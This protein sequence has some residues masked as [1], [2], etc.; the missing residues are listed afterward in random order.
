MCFAIF[1]FESFLR[2]D[3]H[4]TQKQFGSLV[5]PIFLYVGLY[6]YTLD[7]QVNPAE[8][9]RNPQMKR[10]YLQACGP[11]SW[12]PGLYEAGWSS[13]TKLFWNSNQNRQSYFLSFSVAKVKSKLQLKHSIST[14]YSTF[15]N[16]YPR[17]CVARTRWIIHNLQPAKPQDVLLILIALFRP[18]PGQVKS[19]DVTKNKSSMGNSRPSLSLWRH[20]ISGRE[21]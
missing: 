19:E 1:L 3:L 17:W 21:N 6:M 15:Q 5:Y 8:N 2:L 10:S 12:I 18:G 7:W 11:S 9:K 20:A 14:T 13:N 4:S 16:I